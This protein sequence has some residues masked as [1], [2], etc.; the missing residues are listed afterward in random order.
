MYSGCISWQK[1]IF[2]ASVEKSTHLIVFPENPF[3]GN[4]HFFQKE[5]PH[6]HIT[7][8]YSAL[9]HLLCSYTERYYAL[10]LLCSYTTMLLQGER[11]LLCSLSLVTI[12]WPKDGHITQVFTIS[13]S[14]PLFLDVAI[15]GQFGS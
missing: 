3:E 5:Y 8:S 14:L 6:S 13:L 1:Y 2:F 9:L 4:C 7:E 11:A 15:Q 10:M 12:N